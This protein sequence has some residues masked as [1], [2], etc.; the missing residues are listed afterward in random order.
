VARKR[1]SDYDILNLKTPEKQSA[2]IEQIQS[3]PVYEIFTAQEDDIPAPSEVS[4][5]DV[6][7]TSLTLN[8]MDNVTIEYGVDVTPGKIRSTPENQWKHVL[9]SRSELI[10]GSRVPA[11]AQMGMTGFDPI[12][13]TVIVCVPIA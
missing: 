10:P 8:W 2:P 4:L 6:T 1:F 5:S 9:I 12:P 7:H 11:G 13:S 3:M